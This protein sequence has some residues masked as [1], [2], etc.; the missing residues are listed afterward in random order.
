MNMILSVHFQHLEYIGDEV[1]VI[2]ITNHPSNGWF[3]IHTNSGN[4]S[5]ALRRISSV[6]FAYFITC[7]SPV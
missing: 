2:K 3:V 1:Q 5:T 6:A 7:P 4:A